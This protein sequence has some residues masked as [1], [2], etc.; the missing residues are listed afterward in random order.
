MS[1]PETYMD[2][3]GYLRYSDSDYLVHRRVMEKKLGRRLERGEIVHHINGNKFD[4]RPENLELLTAK[5]H[6]KRHVVPILE[7]RR[8]ARIIEN[9]TPRIEAQAVKAILIGFAT[10]GA[11]LLTVGLITGTR[12]A[13]WYVGLLFLLGT[14]AGWFIQRRGK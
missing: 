14:L 13:M 4:N 7:E 9:L 6:Y 12:L 8:E 1:N 10:L 5:E 2:K 11:I 3:H